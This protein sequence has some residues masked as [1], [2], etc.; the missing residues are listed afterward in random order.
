[1]A[2][3]LQSREITWVEPREVRLGGRSGGGLDEGKMYYA[4][5]LRSK[6]CCRLYYGST[7]DLK[8]RLRQ[9]NAGESFATKPYLP[10][11]LAFY[12]A[13]ETET[14]ARNFEKYLKS[15]SG[16]AFAKK[17]FIK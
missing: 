15:S 13:F 4:Y 7:S 12:A 8:T 5:I 2:F 6:G 10:W 1:M 16:W 17:R 11:E 3:P 9:H 14:L